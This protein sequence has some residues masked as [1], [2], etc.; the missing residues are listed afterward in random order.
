MK[1]IIP[2]YKNL[3]D[4]LQD[5]IDQEHDASEYYTEA[6]ELAQDPDV[7]Q[8]LMDLARMEEDHHRMLIDKLESLKADQQVMDGI[9]ASYSDP[10]E[11]EQNN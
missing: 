3:V 2:T 8:F 4:I 9:L 6:A 1:R 11:D 7:K 5:A 10:E